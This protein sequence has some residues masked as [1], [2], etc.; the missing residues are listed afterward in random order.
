VLIVIDYFMGKF[1]TKE[2]RKELLA[3]LQLERYRR[4]ADRI[5]VILLLD[6]SEKYKDI[7]KL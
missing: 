3:E 4:Y 7:A 1:L 2:Q 6:E 5:R